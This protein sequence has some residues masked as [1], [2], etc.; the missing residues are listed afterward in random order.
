MVLMRLLVLRLLKG[1]SGRIH[2]RICHRIEVVKVHSTFTD[3]LQLCHVHL[4]QLLIIGLIRLGALG[5]DGVFHRVVSR[6]RHIA[7]DTRS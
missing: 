1:I 4:L 2:H 6:F 3:L 7:P 5:V